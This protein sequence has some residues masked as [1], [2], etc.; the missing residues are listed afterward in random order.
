M[1]E[2]CFFNIYNKAGVVGRDGATDKVSKSVSKVIIHTPLPLFLENFRSDLNT[3]R[4]FNLVFKIKDEMK[5]LDDIIGFTAAYAF[6]SVSCSLMRDAKDK[7]EEAKCSGGAMDAAR[8]VLEEDLFVSKT[9]RYTG[10]INRLYEKLLLWKKSRVVLPILYSPTRSTSGCEMLERLL[11]LR[12]V[13]VLLHTKFLE[14][15]ESNLMDADYEL[16]SGLAILIT[17]NGF[18]TDLQSAVSALKFISQATTILAEEKSNMSD[19]FAAFLFVRQKLSTVTSLRTAQR[20][21][22]V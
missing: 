9:I 19:A 14:A 5:R 22:V 10:V 16:P 1:Y 11:L 6:V 3:D 17:S 2:R 8:N 4:T 21:G 13:M 20:N 18:W 7:P 15:Q 12:S